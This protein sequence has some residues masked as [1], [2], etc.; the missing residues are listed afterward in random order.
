MTT[1]IKSLE[2]FFRIDEDKMKSTIS[3][4]SD[5]VVSIA[6]EDGHEILIYPAETK[7]ICQLL[8]DETF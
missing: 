8:N 2:V 1:I 6:Q 5:G 4:H 7:A 3:L